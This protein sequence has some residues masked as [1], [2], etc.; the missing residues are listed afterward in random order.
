MKAF[1]AIWDTGA[2]ASVITQDVVD[3][4]GL[5]ATG[6]LQV[7]GVHGTEL[8]ETFLVNIALPN[9]VAFPLV[10]VTKGK[11]VG[12]AHALIGM[13]IIGAGDF[14][15]TNFGN[16]TVMSFRCPSVEE[17]DFVKDAAKLQQ[18]IPK[19]SSGGMSGGNKKGRRHR[20]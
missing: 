11:L 16:R 9:A 20:R 7:H 10:T 19:G 15:V 2:S 12:G 13:D 3:S 5:K 18:K 4:C 8:A 6:V 14:S 17:R 1:T